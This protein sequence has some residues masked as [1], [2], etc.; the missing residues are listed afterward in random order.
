MFSFKN[1]RMHEKLICSFMLVSFIP[2]LI[3]GTVTIIHF[4]DF[5]LVSSAKEI[6]NELNF[7]KLKILEMANEAV[8]IANKLMIDQRLKEL[9]LHRYRSPMETYLK[10]SQYREIENYK[11]LYNRSIFHIR[12]Y[13]E[14][15]TIL[16]NGI[17]YKVKKETLEK[18]WYKLAIQLNGFIIWDLIYQDEDIYPD[19]YFSLVRLL[20][21]VYNEKFGVLVINLNKLE[22]KSILNHTS[23]DT[24]L[25]NSEGTIIFA[26]NEKFL[27]KRIDINWQKILSEDGYSFEYENKK[28]RVFGTYLPLTG[29]NKDF[30]LLSMVPVELIMKEPIRMQ[31]FAFT[32]IF[33]SFLSSIAITFILSKSMS[34]RIAVLNRAVNEISH[35]NWDLEI[36]IEGKDEIGELSENVKVMAK[37]IK[38]LNELLMMQKDMKFKILTNQLNPHFLFNT[39]ET[40]HMMAVCNGQKEIADIVLKLGKILRKTIESK[41]DPIKLE[42]E[43]EL[44]RNYL[45]I[46]KY[47]L[48]RLDYDIEILTDISRVYILPFLIQ[49][50]VENS[51]IHGL[52]DRREGGLIKIKVYSKEGKLIISVID[53]GK[54]MKEEE[55]IEIMSNTQR[56][57]SHRIGLRN[58]MERIKLFYG[59][60]YGLEIKSAKGLGTQVDIILPYSPQGGNLNV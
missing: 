18:S 46:Q 37:N 55:L 4:R 2:I 28:Y 26:N 24:F 44:V 9:L 41:G 23:Y 53:N 25:I 49:P 58:T 27:N 42:T 50:I 11:T 38:S 39:L 21:D 29:Y 17:F 54:G 7:A 60:G 36:P 10:Y 20:R 1:M 15:P 47:R 57:N 56:E 34:R 48:G 52:E 12:I 31:Y 30:Y 6:Y 35:G 19:Y 59:E 3:L 45:E 14:N 32:I 33:L 43:L 16:E 40:I 51:V 22:L 13:S 5:A 8:N